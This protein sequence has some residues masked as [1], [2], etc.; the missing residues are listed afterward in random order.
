MRKLLLLICLVI[1]TAN[2][3]VP[4]Q[5]PLTGTIG[6]KGNFSLLGGITVQIPNGA[7]SV[8]LTPDQAANHFIN[9]TS[10]VSLTAPVSIIAPLNI[11]Q[12]YVVQNKTTGGQFISFGGPTGT[13][14]LIGDGSASSLFSDGTNY[15]QSAVSTGANNTWSGTNG[16]RSNVSLFSGAIANS[17]TNFAAPSFTWASSL[18]V[19]AGCSGT[20]NDLWVAVPVV[21]NGINAPSTLKFMHT[22]GT[23][24]A[25]VVDLPTG[26]TLGGTATICT[27]A[28]GCGT[29]PA[30]FSSTPGIPCNT[31][32]NLSTGCTP[33]Q[34]VAAIGSTPVALAANAT[35]AAIA[36]SVGRVPFQG[37]VVPVFQTVSSFDNLGAALANPLLPR[38]RRRVGGLY[39][40]YSGIWLSQAPQ[41]G[42]HQP[43]HQKRRPG[44]LGSYRYDWHDDAGNWSL[45]WPL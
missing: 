31:S 23:S 36:N 40:R 37:T 21:G 32:A 15:I 24:G 12:D 18:C 42:Q 44:Y 27:S 20:G 17:T 25:A 11:G 1:A 35:N 2:A 3:Q 28:T 19:V 43:H 30:P 38:E 4:V 41:R 10:A 7:S 6:A 45:D 29:G 16:F 13:G 26:S 8:T 22:T 9:V 5:I 14:V 39:S 33:A 34:L